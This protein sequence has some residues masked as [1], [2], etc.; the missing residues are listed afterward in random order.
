MGFDRRLNSR[1]SKMR[2]WHVKQTSAPLPGDRWRWN[3]LLG[4]VKLYVLSNDIRW[5]GSGTM[6]TDD[7][8]CTCIHTVSLKS[9]LLIWDETYRGADGKMELVCYTDPSS[10]CLLPGLPQAIPTTKKREQCQSVTDEE[11]LYKPNVSRTA[12]YFI[13]TDFKMRYIMYHAIITPTNF[14]ISTTYSQH[15]LSPA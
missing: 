4:K 6:T 1:A 3:A 5:F 9:Y 11:S 7:L 8:R 10:A 14:H 12:L 2:W 13:R 15:R